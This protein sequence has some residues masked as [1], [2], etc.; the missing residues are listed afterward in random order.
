MKLAAHNAISLGVT[1]L[2]LH[3]TL[4]G[5][6]AAILTNSVID[7]LGHTWRGKWQ[8]RTPFTHAILTAPLW[9]L[10]VGVAVGGIM[11][12]AGLAN[13]FSNTNFIGEG[14]IGGIISAFCHLFLDSLTAAGI[15]IPSW[16]KVNKN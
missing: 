12:R 4:P 5:F 14:A 16:F 8:H 9:G 2:V 6:A 1:A 11:T 10:G 13:W 3:F 15:F 7:M